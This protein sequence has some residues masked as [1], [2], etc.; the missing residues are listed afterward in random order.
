M[1]Y[2]DDAGLRLHD[3]DR[4]TAQAERR[5]Q[6]LADLGIALAGDEEFDRF[7]AELAQAFAAEFGHRGRTPYAMVNFVADRQM[8]LGLH[9]PDGLPPVGRTMPVDHGYCPEVVERGKALVLP[10]VYA[11]PRF[12][13]NPVVDQIGIRSYAGAPLVH[14]PTGT[15]LGT[16]CVVDDQ[17]R[18][19]STAQASHVL[20]KQHRDALM[21]RLGRTG[22]LPAK[23]PAGGPNTG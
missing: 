9:S 15:V 19:R 22:H 20:I 7:A 18:P 1:R 10:D 12:A 14:Q 21:A 6:L 5:L 4:D 23:G 11:H 16:V 13:G 3:P 17:P 2:D 8:F